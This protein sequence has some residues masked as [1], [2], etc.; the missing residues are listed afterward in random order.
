M[1]ERKFVFKRIAKRALRTKVSR[2]GPRRVL[3]DS[4]PRAGKE[5]VVVATIRHPIGFATDL[6]S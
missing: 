3:L 4:G 5:L 6:F 2:C 1:G